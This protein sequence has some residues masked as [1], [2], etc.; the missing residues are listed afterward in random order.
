MGDHRT[1]E[2]VPRRDGTVK[3]ADGRRLGFAEYG[4]EGGDPVLWFHGTPGA[5]HQISP[6]VNAIAGERGVRIIT[7]E[8]PGVG[9]STPHL[10]DRILDWA[11]DI[12]QLTAQLDVD[13][14]AIA[15][16]SGGGPYVLA[17]AYAFPDRVVAGAVLGGVAPTQGEDGADGG[18][19]ALANRFR[20]PLE[21]LRE[22]LGYTLWGAAK[23]LMPFG[24]Q[25]FEIYLRT[26]PPG[27]QRVFRM[28][29]MKEMFLKDI[30][31]GS[32]KRFHAV[33]YDVVLFT[34]DW[35][36]SPRD[37]RVP[38]RFWHG[39]EDH[40]VPLVH[41]HHVAS[42]MPDA[43]VYER[44]GESHLGSLAA[45][46]EV[47]DVLLGL[48]PDRA[49]APAETASAPAKKPRTRTRKGTGT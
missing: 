49:G 44:P 10:H 1:V 8:R 33:I 36:F 13:R 17:C 21:W 12:D 41:G 7:V 40:I 3:L 45:F 6:D 26:S 15:G 30:S 28:P 48:W 39:D 34:R 38:I 27:D 20:V 37:V 31:T 22:P 14:F 47:L 46:G 35:G 19:V 2:P 4:A 25:A 9:D 24:D 11:G 42:L 43:E 23:L 29:G 18:L 5:R 16:L 32:R